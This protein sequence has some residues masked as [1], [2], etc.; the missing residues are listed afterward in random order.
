MSWADGMVFPST[1]YGVAA[2]GLLAAKAP[3]WHSG[4]FLF[5]WF[6]KARDEKFFRS[7]D[8]HF[9]WFCSFSLKST[10]YDS[11]FFVSVSTLFI[12]LPLYNILD[13]MTGLSNSENNTFS[14]CGLFN[15]NLIQW[16]LW[17]LSSVEAFKCQ[18]KLA[19]KCPNLLHFLHWQNMTVYW[20]VRNTYF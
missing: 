11:L 7:A 17:R 8:Q 15:V 5:L 13:T 9:F 19:F 1:L 12:F 3:H 20:V 10:A 4:T 6:S 2:K 18:N 16:D 14:V